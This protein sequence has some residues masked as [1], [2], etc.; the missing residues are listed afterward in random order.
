MSPAPLRRL[1]VEAPSGERFEALVPE[2]VTLAQLAADFFEQEGWPL[3]DAQGSRLRAVVQLVNPAD[4]SD[5]RRLDDALTVAEANLR[6]GDVLRIVPESP[7]GGGLEPVGRPKTRPGKSIRRYSDVSFPQKV[8]AGKAT[9]LRVAI[10]LRPPHD[11]DVPLDVVVPPLSTPVAVTVSVAAENFTLHGEPEAEITVPPE[12]G[13]LPAVFRLTGD[14]PGPGRVMVDFF[15]EGR[16]LGSVDLRPEV[17]D[18]EPGAVAD[19]AGF[20]AVGLR[21]GGGPGPDVTLV[22][23]E[24]GHSPGR[25]HFTLVSRHPRLR[26]LPLV[27]YGDLGWV[28][29]K[30]DV[31]VWTERQLASLNP[32]ATGAGT[33]TLADVG[34]R[35]YEEVLPGPLQALCWTLAGRGVRSVLVLSDEPHVPWELVKPRRP[36]PD[37]GE[38]DEEPF[39]GESFALTRWVRG[40]ALA[41]QWAVRQVCA[42]AA[43]EVEQAEGQGPTQET[44]DAE[45]Q[46][47]CSLKAAGRSVRVLQPRLDEV[48][49]AFLKGDFD[50]FHLAGHGVFGG[51]RAGD[52]SAVW[53]QGGRFQAADLVPRMAE[54]LRR[55]APLVFFN[56]CETAR[57][58]Y[59]LTQLGSWAGRLL[60]LGCGGFVGT[61]WVVTD[62]GALTFAEAFYRLLFQG[63]PVGE[64]VRLARLE[65]HGKHPG[66]PTWLAYCCFADPLAV[67]E[68]AAPGGLVPAS[69]P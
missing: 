57:L 29:L 22:V 2:D 59:S 54:A 30:E 20:G 52:A 38:F 61:L 40:P 65:V 32:S 50:L 49:Q 33:Q 41:G 26:Y 18:G 45:M 31:A 8:R 53:L 4:P 64:A 12:G 14:R 69:R 19:A 17:V 28:D 55:A 46:V 47:L 3:P 6:D 5:V 66:D 34:H 24:Y 1:I 21:A 60:R 27:T 63:T 16:P 25:L 36:D 35:L 7:A 23:H 39:W 51:R 44:A 48:R 58:G 43:V 62:N 56:A 42:T 37:T 13:S 11:H 68:G 67:V 10:G 15:Q 9:V